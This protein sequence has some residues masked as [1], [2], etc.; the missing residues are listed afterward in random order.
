MFI[1]VEENKGAN[2]SDVF[3]NEEGYLFIRYLYD[4]CQILVICLNE[5]LIKMWEKDTPF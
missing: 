1:I 3:I 4:S 2:D 5:K